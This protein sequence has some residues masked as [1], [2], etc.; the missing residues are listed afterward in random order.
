MRRVVEPP[1]ATDIADHDLAGLDADAGAAEA[2]RRRI[3]FGAELL[4]ECRNGPGAVERLG[5]VIV[6]IDRGVENRMQAVADD[7]LHHAAVIDDDAH[8]TLEIAVEHRHQPARAGALGHGGEAFD[9]S[10]QGRHHPRLT[11]ELQKA[12][13]FEQAAHDRRR[14][15]LFEPAA[16][17]SFPQPHA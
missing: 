3:A 15:L 6:E 13:F 8:D 17:R 12:R 11:L 4:G 1:A 5:R 7:L 16:D 9:V 10:E 14:Q 2:Q